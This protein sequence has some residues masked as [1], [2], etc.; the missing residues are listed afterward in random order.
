MKNTSAVIVQTVTRQ[1]VHIGM[2]I[3][4]FRRLMVVWDCARI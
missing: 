4:E 2:R 1:I 3:E